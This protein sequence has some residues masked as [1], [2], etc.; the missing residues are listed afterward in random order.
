MVKKAAEQV[1]WCSWELQAHSTQKAAGVSAVQH[2]RW[3]YITLHIC[4]DGLNPQWW[5]GRIPAGSLV[6]LFGFLHLVDGVLQVLLHPP[7]LWVQAHFLVGL[8]LGNHLEGA[9]RCVDEPELSDVTSW[10]AVDCWATVASLHQADGLCLWWR[11][12]YQHHERSHG[13]Q[14]LRIHRA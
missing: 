12:T 8:Q 9:V 4:D 10:D 2:I 11:H 13:C 6:T 7:D 5:L 14:K 3:S 1:D